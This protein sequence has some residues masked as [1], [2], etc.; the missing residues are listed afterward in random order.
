MVYNMVSSISSSLWRRCM[1]IARN[2][3]E[4][5]SFRKISHTRKLG[6]ITIFYAVIKTKK[7]KLREKTKS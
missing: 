2:H 1:R 5:V 3:E 7:F 6:E 4:T